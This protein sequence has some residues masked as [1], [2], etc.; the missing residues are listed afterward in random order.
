MIL[1]ITHKSPHLRHLDRQ[2]QTTWAALALR[3]T[4]R[5]LS[6]LVCGLH[7]ET[8]MAVIRETK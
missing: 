4:D 7:V 6:A 8:D 2:E 1:S 5:E 3:F